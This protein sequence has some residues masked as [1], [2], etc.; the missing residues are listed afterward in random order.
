MLIGSVP[1]W[2]QFCLIDGIYFAI[3]TQ[4]AVKKLR[5]GT[6]TRGKVNQPSASL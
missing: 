3:A 5:Q 6:I 1:C 4:H 2:R